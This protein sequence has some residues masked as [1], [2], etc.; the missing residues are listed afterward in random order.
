MSHTINLHYQR[1]NYLRLARDPKEIHINQKLYKEKIL[2]HVYF[3]NYFY[4]LHSI[5]HLNDV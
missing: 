3:V 4:L 1:A 2:T 5:N